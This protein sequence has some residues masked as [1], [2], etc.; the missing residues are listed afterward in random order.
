MDTKGIVKSSILTVDL[1]AEMLSEKTYTASLINSI[2]LTALT[3]PLPVFLGR[4]WN[5]H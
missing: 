3:T 4:Q 1:K 5:I 2:F